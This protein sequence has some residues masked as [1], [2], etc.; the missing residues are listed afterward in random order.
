MLCNEV[1]DWGTR[2]PRSL[3]GTPV[4]LNLFVE[5]ADELFLRAIATGAR[6]KVAPR[7]MLW[8]DRFSCVV[9]PFGHEWMIAT[10]REA[11]TPDEIRQRIEEGLA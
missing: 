4:P 7:D 6:V 1:E 5:D 8:G 2:W 11:P 9:D 10:R 3:G